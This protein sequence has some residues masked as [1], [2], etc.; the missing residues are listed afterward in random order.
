VNDLEIIIGETYMENKASIVLSGATIYAGRSLPTNYDYLAIKENKIIKVGK[1][2]VP[3]ALI[4]E[5]TQ[6]YEFTKDSLITAG[7]HDNH[8]HIILAGMLNKYVC[9]DNCT[10]QEQVAQKAKGFAETIPD[11]EWVI[12]FGF[13]RAEWKDKSLPLKS[14]LDE[15]IPNRPT[16]LMDSEFH[17]AWANSKAFELA[18]INA[19][20]T[21]P[22]F[23]EIVR[24]D[25]GEPKGFLYESAIALIAKYAFD[26]DE[27]VVTDFIQR[28]MKCAN[29][30]G[31]TSVSDITPYLGIDLSYYDVFR[32]LANNHELTLRINAAR[33]LFEDSGVLLS[34]QEEIRMM[35]SDMY[36]ISY[37]K[38]FI[39]G[40]PANYTALMLEDYS[41][42]PDCKGGTLIPLE[43]LNGAVEHANKIGIPVKLHACGDKAVRLAL[44]AFEGAALAMHGCHALES[45]KASG[46]E[47]D[48]IRNQVEHIEITTEKDIPRFSELG[49]IASVQPEHIVSG[50]NSHTDNCYPELLGHQRERFTWPF[51]SLINQGAVIACGSDMPVV[52]GVPFEGLYVGL[53]RLH[54]DGSP[55]GG[56]NS[57][58]KITIE[59]L[60]DGY[61]IGSAFA[62]YKEEELGT[63]EAGKLADISVFDTNFLSAKPEQIRNANAV[64]TIVDGKIVYE[65]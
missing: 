5:N 32:R 23:G 19:N 59:E 33:N 49:V 57:R 24:T 63:I 48:F 26:F 52:A 43:K 3:E 10:S 11:E 41:D 38:Q 45:S 46:Y 55:K 54:N 30:Y 64:M 18:G 2:P 22:E 47:K 27:N 42:K 34:M 53:T 44:D 25:N 40:V 13:S 14:T 16:L 20:T 50:I 7:L 15:Y 36:R 28:Y 29:S 60:L 1:G 61:T 12:G 31:I 51:R 56:W 37:Y 21:D 8:V 35:D 39:D 62:E 58:E 6:I 4:C 65:K 9:L 17:S